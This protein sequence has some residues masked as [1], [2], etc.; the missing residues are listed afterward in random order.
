MLLIFVFRDF[1]PSLRERERERSHEAVFYVTCSCAA[2]KE[3]APANFP[4]DPNFFFVQF[5]STPMSAMSVPEMLARVHLLS[6]APLS[7]NISSQSFRR[8]M[9]SP[10]KTSRLIIPACNKCA[11][12]QEDYR[13]YDKS[14]HGNAVRFT[15]CLGLRAG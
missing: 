13:G 2:I 5:I 8:I 10:C 9:L 4:R 11:E 6:L 1:L 15:V 7:S 3:F 12:Y 14:G